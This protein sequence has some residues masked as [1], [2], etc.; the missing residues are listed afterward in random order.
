MGTYWIKLCGFFLPILLLIFSC[1]SIQPL[2]KASIPRNPNLKPPGNNT[3]VD[4]QKTE[5]AA[6]DRIEETHT[7]PASQTSPV[8][9]SALSEV[10]GTDENALTRTDDD[11]RGFNEKKVQ[12]ILDEALEYCQASQEFWQKGELENAVEALDQAYALILKINIDDQPKLIQQQDDLRFLI[13]KRILEIYASRNIVVNGKHQAIPTVINRYVETEIERFTRGEEKTFFIESYKRSGRYRPFIKAALIEAG[14]PAE[15]SWLPL[16]ESGFKVNAF[17]RARALGL[18]QF[19]PSTGYKFGLKRNKYIDERLDPEKSTRAA[20]A[21]L[22]ELHQ[23][24]GDWTTVMAAYNCGEGRVLRVIRH[25]NINYLDNFWDLYERLPFETARYV[26]RF[27]ATL[28]IINNLE[29]YGLDDIALDPPV[30]YETVA[31]SK[32]IH[33]KNVAPAIGVSLEVLKGLNPELRYK[34]LPPDT[35]ALKVPAN[36][37]EQLLA[38]INEIPVSSPPK[39][40]FVYHRVRR[41]ET[42]STI[43]RRYRTSVRKIMRANNLRRSNYIVAGRLLKIPQ[44][45]YEYRPPKRKKL[46]PKHGPTHTVARG[47][48][49][50]IIANHYGTTTQKIQ[51]LNNLSSAELYIGQILILPQ[52]ASGQENIGLKTYRV[53]HGDSPFEIA[54]RHNMSLDRLL[55]MN[56]LTTRSTIYPGQ[57][58]VVE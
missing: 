19:I 5:N 18:W 22:K 6:T 13:S 38:K 54:A 39:P 28:H 48:S 17:S 9:V 8:E 10:S 4:S 37:G 40:T 23:I 30:E 36:K 14:L 25:Q 43:A 41:G 33:L 29:Q 32:Q 20:I 12:P 52:G 21:Y 15:L 45:G 47:D 31:V 56:N 53:E 7:T 50:W 46:K 49:L 26:P 27:L 57:K 58:L 3:P 11:A 16:I 51:Q 24:F 34:L 42:L 1:T 2:F 44:R 35:Y 55:R